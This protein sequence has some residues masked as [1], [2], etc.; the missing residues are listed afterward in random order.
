MLALAGYP[1]GLQFLFLAPSPNA[2]A[3]QVAEQRVGQYTDA[4]GLK[5]LTECDVVTFEFENVPDIAARALTEATLVFPPPAALQVAQ[6]RLLEK[7]CFQELGIPTPQFRAVDN[8][9]DLRQAVQQLGLPSVLKT[10]RFGY[11]GKG[12][13]LLKSESDASE[14]LASVGNGALILEEF[15]HFSRE[16]SLVAVR[17]RSGACQCYPL[18]ENTH[19]SGILRLSQAPT[20]TPEA[21]QADAMHSVERLLDHLDYVGVLTVEFFDVNGKLLANEFAPRVHNSGHL[22]IEGAETS[23]FENHLRAICD[24]PLGSTRMLGPTAMLNLIGELPDKAAVLAI[25]GSHY[26][27]YGKQVRPGRK[28]GHITLTAGSESELAAR[29]AACRKLLLA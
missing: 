1:L 26:H 23:Q 12:Q 18:I 2:P 16:L 25:P 21:V 6:D 15:V 4:A 7:R 19:K 11:D 20:N 29:V 27:D 3:G 9:A 28:L 8:E 5:A 22:S 17:S 14:A 24:L 13:Y 10:R